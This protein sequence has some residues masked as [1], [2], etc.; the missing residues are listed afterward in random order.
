MIRVLVTGAAGKMGLEVLKAVWLADETELVGAVDVQGAGRDIG[1]MMGMG[2]LGLSLRSDLAGAL[3]DLRPDVMVDFT[4]PQVVAENVNLALK[5]GVRPVVGTTGLDVAELEKIKGLAAAKG[6]GCVIAPNFAIG[7]L[8]MIKF[9]AEASR[10]MPHVEI[11]EL[12]HDRK[13][14]APSGTALMTAEAISQVRG[15]F[16]QGLAT[17]FEKITCSRGGK[18]DGGIRLHSVRLPGLVAHQEVIFGGLGQTLTIRHDSISRESFMPGVLVAI[19]K[20]MKLKEMVYGLDNLIF[21]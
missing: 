20:V 1:L 5:A 19:R 18:F 14:D 10:Y 4:S 11:I 3:E 16:Q 7:A 17:E 8:L 13:L 6:L 15:D 2:E 21:E 12:H 9:A